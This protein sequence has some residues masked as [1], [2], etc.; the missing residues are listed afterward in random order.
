MKLVVFGLIW[1]FAQTNSLKKYMKF[2]TSFAEFNTKY[3]ANVTYSLEQD[4]STV[5]INMEYDLIK[6]VGNTLLHYYIHKIREVKN[7]TYLFLDDRVLGCDVLKTNVISHLDYYTQ[8]VL[9]IDRTDFKK[10]YCYSKV[11][12]GFEPSLQPR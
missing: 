11:C 4:Q 6:Y 12:E 3:M 10:M 7:E 8:K 5:S 2:H 1:V 9:K